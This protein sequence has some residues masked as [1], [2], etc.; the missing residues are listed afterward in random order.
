MCSKMK[1]YY[2]HI[3]PIVLYGLDYVS[4]T[5]KLSAQ[6][7]TFQNTTMCII[8]DPKLI[9]NVK[10]TTLGNVTNML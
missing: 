10:I 9:D 8:I 3:V 5:Q 1:I 6:I 4:L 7:E 2:I